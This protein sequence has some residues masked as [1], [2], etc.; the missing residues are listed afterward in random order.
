MSFSKFFKILNYL[1]NKQIDNLLGRISHI[2][3]LA[4]KKNTLRL[5]GK[6]ANTS[7]KNAKIQKMITIIVPFVQFVFEVL[8]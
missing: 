5:L 3:I 4:L 8:Q 2:R 1:K 7:N 6:I